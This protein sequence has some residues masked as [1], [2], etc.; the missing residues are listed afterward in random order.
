[1]IFRVAEDGLDDLQHGSEPGAASNHSNVSAGP[2]VYWLPGLV[3]L[4]L[5]AALVVEVA[6]RSPKQARIPDL[7]RVDVLAHLPPIG[8][9]WRVGLVD[10]HD[11]G[12]DARLLVAGCGCV[13]TD[14]LFVLGI[15]E[16]ERN[17]LSDGKPKDGLGTIWVLKG[18]PDGIMANLLLLDELEGAEPIRPQSL[19]SGV[20]QELPEE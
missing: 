19:P 10:L 20:V 17:V 15:P 16:L 14:H 13:A 3:D 7:E 18:H 11:K 8:K 2:L 12:Y 1:M 6:L 5:S 4:E 9:L